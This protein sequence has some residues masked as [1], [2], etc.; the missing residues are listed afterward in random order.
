MRNA[1]LKTL[2]V[3]FSMFFCESNLKDLRHAIL[4]YEYETCAK[5][6]TRNARLITVFRIK[7]PI[8]I[9]QIEIL[10]LQRAEISEIWKHRQILEYLKKDLYPVF[11]ALCIPQKL[12]VVKN[13]NNGH[14]HV[15]KIK[16]Y[17]ISYYN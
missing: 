10:Y 17:L 11:V 13:V 5:Y 7:K 16:Y 8:N 4:P 1:A 15:T 2:D 12:L 14:N 6:S 9:L 3:I